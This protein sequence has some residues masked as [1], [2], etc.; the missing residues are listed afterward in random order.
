[1]S[2]SALQVVCALIIHGDRLLA[3]RRDPSRAFPLKW[4]FPGG[5]LEPG[6][7]AEAALHRELEEE[8][9]FRVRITKSL[10][11]VRFRE[12]GHCLDLIPF[13]CQPDQAHAPRPVDHVEIRWLAVDSLATLDWAPAD[14]PLLEQLPGL[15]SRA[16]D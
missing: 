15:I 12:N 13:L 10:E 2:D 5:K 16:S 6:E 9:D 3:T 4:E 7:S 14:V 8:L 1:M 11:P